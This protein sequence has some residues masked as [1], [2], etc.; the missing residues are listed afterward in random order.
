[1]QDAIED[2]TITDSVIFPETT[3][4]HG[5]LR[6]SL[7]ERTFIFAECVGVVRVFPN[8]YRNGRVRY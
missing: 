4:K 6:R 5:G 8:T 3:I 1:M 7:S 2:A